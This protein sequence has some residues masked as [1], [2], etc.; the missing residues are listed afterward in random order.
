[1]KRN[2][3]TVS[4]AQ[5]GMAAMLP[6]MVRMVELMQAQVDELRAQLGQMQPPGKKRGRPSL[7][8]L[9]QRA[10]ALNGTP[11]PRAASGWPADPEARRAE[12]RRRMQVAAAKNGQALVSKVDNH[13]R[14]PG[15]PGHAKW[16]AKMKKTRKKAWAVMTEAQRKEQVQRMVAGRGLKV[17]S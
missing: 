7:A 5:M 16:V 1:M 10:A 13:P 14:S 3:E 17:A 9:E 4:Y 6:G 15:H 2:D 8:D 12:M 11:S